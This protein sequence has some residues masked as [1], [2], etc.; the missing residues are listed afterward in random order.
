MSYMDSMSYMPY[1]WALS[2]A[3]DHSPRAA[4]RVTQPCVTRSRA[5]LP[6]LWAVGVGFSQV[7]L[8]LAIYWIFSTHN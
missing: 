2:L 3:L 1:S 6:E 5:T 7:M 8:M 4:S